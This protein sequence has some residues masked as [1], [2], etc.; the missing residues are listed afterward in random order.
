MT[1]ISWAAP[2]RRRAPILPRCART[3]LAQRVRE[4][5]LEE[6]RGEQD[7]V[8]GQL[9]P[10]GLAES[11]VQVDAWAETYG[12]AKATAR[13]V[14][15][16]MEGAGAPDGPIRA[17]FKATERDLSEADGRLARISLDFIIWHEE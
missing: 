5:G 17:A 10:D 11:R 6:G 13:A 1:R 12:A 9:G 4:V 2:A 7:D 3:D 16:A 14:C 15:A 8:G